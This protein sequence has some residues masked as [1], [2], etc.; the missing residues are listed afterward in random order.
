MEI[1]IFLIGFIFGAMCIL[2][3]ALIISKAKKNTQDK[4]IE[5]MQEQM[6]LYFENTANKILNDGSEKLTEHNKEKLEEFFTRFR[7]RIELFEKQSLE[8]FRTESEHFTKFDTNIKSFLETG[9]RLVNVMKSDNR[10][11]GRWG[12]IVLER[13]LE[14][15]GLQEGKEYILQKGMNDGRP[16]VTIILPDDKTIYVDS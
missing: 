8:N 5:S 2:I 6:K 10:S 14:L 9:N 15:S 1:L 7:D 13:V 16:D 11:S 4:T 3:P 12:E